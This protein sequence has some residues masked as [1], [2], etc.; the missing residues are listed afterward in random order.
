[1]AGFPGLKTLDDFDYSFAVGASRKTIDE[2]ATPRL[3]ERGENAVLLGSS[4][5]GTM[6]LVIAIG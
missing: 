2:L 1:M 5:V 4:G 6:H 3:I